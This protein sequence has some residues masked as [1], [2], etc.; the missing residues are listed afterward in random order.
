[1][2]NTSL[3]ID[4]QPKNWRSQELCPKGKKKINPLDERS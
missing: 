1:M 2:K 4:I 3:T